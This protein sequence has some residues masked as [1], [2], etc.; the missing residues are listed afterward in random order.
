MLRKSAKV[1]LLRGVPLFSNC[2][3]RELAEIA[4][5]ADEIDFPEGKIL[6]KEGDRGHRVLRL[7][8]WHRRCETTGTRAGL[9][10]EGGLLLQSREDSGEVAKFHRFSPGFSR[11]GGRG[12]A[13]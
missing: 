9:S 5:L 12:T 3:K 4:S 11:L 2:S 7:D 10:R 8:R 13:G 6:I 1:E